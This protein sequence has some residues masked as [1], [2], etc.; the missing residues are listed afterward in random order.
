MFEAVIP[1]EHL[2]DIFTP[3]RFSELLGQLVD[4]L[5]LEV[6]RVES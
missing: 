2:L 3:Q 1:S 5:Q 4:G 6:L